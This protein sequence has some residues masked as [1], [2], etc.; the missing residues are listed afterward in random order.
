M[1]IGVLALQG[2]FREHR[3]M[4][5][6]CGHEVIEVRKPVE[7]DQIQ[8]LIIPGGESTTIT[9]LMREFQLEQAIV[10]R[11]EVGMPIYGTCAG[12]IV[13]AKD[14][15]GSS[16][17]S[18]NLMDISV[19]RNAFGRQIDSFECELAIPVLG[20]KPFAAVFI[21]APLIERVAPNV[22]ILAQYDSKIVF[23][24]QGNFL[25]SSFHPELTNDKRIH[26]YFIQMVE[27][28]INK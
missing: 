16:Q 8:G 6:A 27:E 11:A 12:L 23:A 17:P 20:Y 2:A 1:K 15:I 3:N 24:R 19:Q 14:I 25:A 4:V 22:G 26:Q 10:S 28:A 18:L 13:L 9:K 5:E 7:L 21:R